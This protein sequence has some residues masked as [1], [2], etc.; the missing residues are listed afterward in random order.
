VVV[1]DVEGYRHRRFPLASAKRWIV[2]HRRVPA[3]LSAALLAS[4]AAPSIGPAE[5]VANF[6]IT[7]SEQYPANDCRAASCDE[8]SVTAE[9]LRRELAAQWARIGRSAFPQTE[10][11]WFFFTYWFPIEFPIA[12]GK[13]ASAEAERR[14]TFETRRAQLANVERLM[15]DKQCPAVTPQRGQGVPTPTGI[16]SDWLPDLPRPWYM[17]K[18]GTIE[19][20]PPP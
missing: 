2:V 12:L 4:C 1:K 3:L 10:P 7:T 11:E 6:C 19:P 16:E 20:Q 8:L 18:P 13:L 17:P 9:R 15:R 5:Q 14:T